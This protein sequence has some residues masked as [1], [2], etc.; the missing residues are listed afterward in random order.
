MRR[1]C[2]TSSCQFER[3]RPKRPTM[4]DVTNCLSRASNALERACGSKPTG[5]SSSMMKISAT[6]GI[7]KEEVRVNG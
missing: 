5:A 7:T 2:S 4:H 1:K 3:R 6:S